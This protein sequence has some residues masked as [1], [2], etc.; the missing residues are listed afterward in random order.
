MAKMFYTVEEAAARLGMSEAEVQSLGESGQLQEFRD[1]DRLMFKRD[2]VDLLAGD[3]GGDEIDEIRL[4]ESA[5]L[6]PLSLSSSGSGS[7]FN[8]PPEQSR[9]GESGISIFDPDDSTADANADT[10]ITGSSINPADLAADASSSGSGL[11]Q[12]ALESDDTSLG[13]DLLSELG[14]GDDTGAGMG[15][16]AGSAIGAAAALGDSGAG[17]LFEGGSHEPDFS[18][19]QAQAA[20]L[21]IGEP[22]DGPWSGIAGGAAVGMIVML[23]AGI[24][25]M[26]LGFS[27]SGAS[28]LLGGIQA[29]TLLM[30]LGGG[31]GVVLFCAAIGWFA[32]RKS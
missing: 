3:E 19:Q 17:S 16:A 18:A 13:S 23:V 15:S 32:L 21:P 12:L 28:A 11:A 1:R 4:A 30:I 7:A 29:N 22:Y 8:A 2:Q 20:L 25:A 31:I 26:I 14:S 10:L 27:G 6:E 24:A 9:S 5:E